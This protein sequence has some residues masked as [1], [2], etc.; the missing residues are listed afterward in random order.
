MAVIFEFLRHSWPIFKNLIQ[1]MTYESVVLKYPA[2]K[3]RL[4][5][6]FRVGHVCCTR[7]LKETEMY[8]HLLYIIEKP[9]F[10]HKRETGLSQI[11]LLDLEKMFLIHYLPNHQRL[12]S[13]VILF[14][15]QVEK[16]CK[17]RERRNIRILCTE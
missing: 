6:L 14:K 5:V 11:Y 4:I 12:L 17:N 2:V 13:L 9:P 8:F 3:F 7:L 10:S 1:L 16:Q 15:Y